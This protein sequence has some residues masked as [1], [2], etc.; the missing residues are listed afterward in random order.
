LQ[1]VRVGE[2]S[3]ASLEEFMRKIATSDRPSGVSSY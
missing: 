1:G 3:A 2:L